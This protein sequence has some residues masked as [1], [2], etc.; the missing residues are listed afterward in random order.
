MSTFRIFI[1]LISII[2][3]QAEAAHIWNSQSDKSKRVK[4]VLEGEI[5]KGDYD[6]LKSILKDKGPYVDAVVLYSPGGDAKEAMKIGSMLHE[7][8][9]TTEAPG[10]TI[11]DI[12][13]KLDEWRV[14]PVCRYPPPTDNKNCVCYSSCF[15]IWVAGINREGR[16]L[17]VHRPRFNKEYYSTLSSVEAQREYKGLLKAMDE[18][19]NHY[20]VLQELREKMKTTPSHEIHTFETNSDMKG[21]VPWYDELLTAKC[22]AM[23]KKQERRYWL[24]TTKGSERTSKKEFKELAQLEK[25]KHKIDFC[26]TYNYLVM[27]IEAFSRY[28]G[29]D[30]LSIIRE[31]K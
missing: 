10:I 2:S 9:L 26:R 7:L 17:G 6:E 29:I 25:K 20:P 3:M 21:F 27:R 18:Y 1:A 15:L 13:G 22:G 4:V 30:Y 28:F 23:P 8:E 19:L 5:K 14:V 16:H 31:S 11:E 24:L 12:K